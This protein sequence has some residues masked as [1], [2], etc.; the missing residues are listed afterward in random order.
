MPLDMPPQDTAS[1]IE[2]EK[3]APKIIIQQKEEESNEAMLNKLMADQGLR[4]APEMK[5]K[6]ANLENPNEE[7]ASAEI[8]K[9]LDENDQ[10]I[11]K[12]ADKED[13]KIASGY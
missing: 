13:P 2:N 10:N 6:K 8:K 1:A 5:I 9:N 4:F 3:E 12:N 11:L 7:V